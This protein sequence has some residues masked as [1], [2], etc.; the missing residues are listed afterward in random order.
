MPYGNGARPTRADTDD[1]GCGASSNERLR[2]VEEDGMTGP[3]EDGVMGADDPTME[4][5]DV[6]FTLRRV[7]GV[8]GPD[9]STVVVIPG[10]R[11]PRV[12]E[13]GVTGPEDD[14]VGVFAEAVSRGDT[15]LAELF[16][17]SLLPPN[18]E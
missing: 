1:R 4:D 2:R 9:E 7:D 15:L 16:A 12:E 14:L 3:E 6:V 5:V 10:L 17:A 13:G 18:D 11:L 8:M